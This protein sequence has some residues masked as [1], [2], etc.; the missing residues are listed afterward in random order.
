MLCANGAS[1][2]AIANITLAVMGN[3]VD[4]DTPGA[5]GRALRI[6]D[7]ALAA[8]DPLLRKTRASA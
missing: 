2:E 7:K 1:T 5:A 4:N 8:A 3:L 6:A